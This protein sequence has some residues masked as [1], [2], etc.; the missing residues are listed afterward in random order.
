MCDQMGPDLDFTGASLS[1]P[2]VSGDENET[3]EDEVNSLALD[4][5]YN[6]RAT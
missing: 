2:A 1:A 6:E 4:S 5:E 3:A